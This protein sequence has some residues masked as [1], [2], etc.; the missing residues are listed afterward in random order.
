MSIREAWNASWD[1]NVTGTHVLTHTA[2]PLLLKSGDPRLLFLM[3]GT[4]SLMETEDATSRLNQAPPKGWPKPP[5]F[6]FPSYRSSKAGMAMMMRECCRLLRDDGV[7]VFCLSP[8]FL[9]SGLGGAG[10]E[11]LKQMGAED[12]SLGGQ[13]IRDVVEGGRDEQVGVVIRRG[14]LVQPW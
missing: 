14:A 4:A 2:M 1:T 10:A 6:D 9:A 3:S 5:H 12:V 11:K 13:F 8:G 7:K